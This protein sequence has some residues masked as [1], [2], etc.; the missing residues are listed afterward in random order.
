MLQADMKTCVTCV[1]DSEV[2]ILRQDA[3]SI[4]MTSDLVTSNT[5]SFGPGSIQYLL[6]LARVALSAC[7][8]V[9]ELWGGPHLT[10]QLRQHLL[11]C[12]QYEVQELVLEG[13]L[14][15]LQEE[16]QERRPEWL[17][18]A[19]LSYLTSLALRETHPQSLAKVRPHTHAHAH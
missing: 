17:D 16:E 7:V 19:T 4:L 8:E 3:L 15:R 9:P 11:S 13:V 6:S 12:T 2:T 10:S 1:P 5:S 14:R 18:K